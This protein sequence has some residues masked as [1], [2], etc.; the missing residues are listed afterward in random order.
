MLA[1]QLLGPNLD[2]MEMSL[3]G[4]AAYQAKLRTAQKF[5]LDRSIGEVAGD[6][7]RPA[8][9]A[10]IPFCRLPFPT[11]W[12]EIAQQDRP[13]FAEAFTHGPNHSGGRTYQPLRVGILCE[14][15]GD[16]PQRFWATLAW[17]YSAA[18]QLQQGLEPLTPRFARQPCRSGAAR[19]DPEAGEPFYLTMLAAPYMAETMQ[20]IADVDPA[21][22]DQLAHN[23]NH[24]WA[25]EPWF[26]LAV[27][28]LLN[29]KNG[30]RSEFRPAAPAL[31]RSRVKAGKPPLIDYHQ[32]TLR[33]GPRDA[34]GRAIEAS[35]AGRA[36][37]RAHAVRGHFKI[38]KTGAYW[39][40]PFIRGDVSEGF[41]NKR[42]K[43]TR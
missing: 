26:W 34:P 9:Q 24:D 3:N 12:I 33:T 22:A 19:A 30:A 31:N 16:N 1:D 40:S 2:L 28:A 27:L 8:V 10:M 15:Q 17:S 6:M 29:A 23:A 11:C 14:Q 38:R 36:A 7:S 5:A 20:R 39:W 25:G 21:V 42:Y 41:A 35:A 4:A 37:M 18:D 32:L 13:R 43:V